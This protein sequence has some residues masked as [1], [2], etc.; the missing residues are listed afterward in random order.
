MQWNITWA[1]IFKIAL[2]VIIIYGL[3]LIKGIILIG[4]SALTISIIFNPAIS[5]FE[6][7]KIPRSLAA[8]FVYFGFLAILSLIF[9]II[10][11]PIAK[12]TMVF[13]QNFSQ[14]FTQYSDTIVSL[15]R[16]D[17]FDIPSILNANPGIGAGIIN[18]SGGVLKFATSFF[19]GMFSVITVFVLAF[20]FSIEEKD[21]VGMIR[22][23]SPKKWEE[24]VLK[25]WT[26]SQEQVMGWFGSRILS[27]FGV[28]ILTFIV[29]LIL[30]IKF[31]VSISLLAAL[32]NIVPLIGPVLVGIILISFALLNSLYTAFL[33][34]IFSILI[35]QIEHNIFL[36]FFTK[37]IV[38]IPNF[39]V[40][41]AILVGG[42]LMGVVGALLAIPLA[43][44]IYETLA[45]YMTYKKDQD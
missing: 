9:Y 19:G 39:L 35:Q 14:Y 34:L 2:T 18:I 25:A 16:V 27:A 37:K 24:S 6:K 44:V 17:T 21:F 13:S 10:I 11:P 5:F 28:G 41:L 3:F 40:L 20:F 23:F 45:N 32:L 30:K 8:F 31:A 43:G 12:E 36:P 42:E 7:K 29:C 1:T 38:G 15:L 4:L 22:K 33:A 26:K